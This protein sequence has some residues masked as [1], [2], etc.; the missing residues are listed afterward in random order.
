MLPLEAPK[1]PSLLSRGGR[2]GCVESLSQGVETVQ[3]PNLAA[4]ES[5]FGTGTNALSWFLLRFVV[6]SYLIY[7]LGIVVMILFNSL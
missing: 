5:V 1:G 2:Y 6:G 4:V 3:Q 7:T